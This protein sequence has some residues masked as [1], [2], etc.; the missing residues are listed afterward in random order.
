MDAALKRRS[1]LTL[2]WRYAEARR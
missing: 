2:P 1:T